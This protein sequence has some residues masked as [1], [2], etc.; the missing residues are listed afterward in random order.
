MELDV[1]RS[2]H[3][4]AE[5]KDFWLFRDRLAI[6]V[7]LL[8]RL[9]VCGHKVK[10]K[11]G[12]EVPQTQ[13]VFDRVLHARSTHTAYRHDATT[14]RLVATGAGVQQPTVAERGQ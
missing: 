2:L 9:R 13:Q 14:C 1:I 12:T 11:A 8:L 7:Q 6:S 4:L 5:T 3:H 10:L